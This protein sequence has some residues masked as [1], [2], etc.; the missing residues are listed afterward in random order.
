M[1]KILGYN[2]SITQ[3][4]LVDSMNTFGRHHAQL[5]HIQLA[6]DL[7]I[8]QTESTIL[9]EIL[10]ALNYYLDLNIPHQSLMS[11]ESTLY[12][13]LTENEV[14]FSPLLSKIDAL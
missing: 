3:T 2:Y 5:Q 12:Q 14:D 6:K 8:Q 7:C 13:T 4:D 1:I 10:E 9:H 11:L